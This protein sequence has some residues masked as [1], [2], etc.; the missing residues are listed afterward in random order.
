M[1]NGAGTSVEDRAEADAL[2]AVLGNH[3]PRALTTKAAFGHLL[4]ASPIVDLLLALR[5][6]AEEEVPPSPGAV[7]PACDLMDFFQ[8]PMSAETGSA[9]VLSQGF[10]GVCAAFSAEMV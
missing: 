9:L 6:L 7:G 2:S 1:T 4:G 8:G 3:R 10:G 5:A